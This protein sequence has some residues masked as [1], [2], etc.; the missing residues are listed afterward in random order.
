V[1]G[2]ERGLHLGRLHVAR[3][4]V[5]DVAVHQQAPHRLA[6]SIPRQPQCD[7]LAGKNCD[8]KKNSV[9]KIE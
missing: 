5:Q 6:G 2:V 7:P 1:G 4:R 8:N 9:T 3:G